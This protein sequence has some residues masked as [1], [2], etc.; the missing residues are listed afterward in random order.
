ML[1]LAL[2]TGV[3]TIVTQIRRAHKA[4]VPGLAVAMLADV[5]GLATAQRHA[6]GAVSAVAAV[7]IVPAHFIRFDG[8]VLKYELPLKRTASAWFMRHRH[9]HQAASRGLDT[10]GNYSNVYRR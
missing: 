9:E 1:L 6:I 4:P 8:I 2:V 10:E 7:R 5:I 3:V